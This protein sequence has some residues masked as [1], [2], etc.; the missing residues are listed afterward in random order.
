MRRARKIFGMYGVV[1]KEVLRARRKELMKQYHPDSG[2][3]LE[4]TKEIN[5]AFDILWKIAV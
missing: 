2:G 5:E 3:D 4:K 1:Y